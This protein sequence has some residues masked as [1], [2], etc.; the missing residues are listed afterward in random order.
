L[1]ARNRTSRRAARETAKPVLAVDVDGVVSIFGFDDPPEGL[2]TRLELIDGLVHC[3]PVDV[4][5]RL[6]RLGRD[7]DLVWATGWEGRANQL[8]ELLGLSELPYLTF[9][10]AARFGSAHWK[11][12]PLGVYAKGQPLAWIDD[13]FD[14]GCY[15]WARERKEPTLLIST[16]SQRGLEETHVEALTA[17]A[18][19]LAA[20]STGS[21]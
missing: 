11:L 15:E 5:E 20:E 7:Y 14:A 2:A 16:E 21:A 6:R 17:W 10:G 12:E 18:R 1:R 8:C 13:S 9:A 3:I 19:S 4:G